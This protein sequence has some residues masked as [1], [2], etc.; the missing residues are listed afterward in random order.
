MFAETAQLGDPSKIV[1]D[2]AI[3]VEVRNP[4]QVGGTLDK[5][6]RFTVNMSTSLGHFTIKEATV[7]RRYRDFVWL[8]D[9]LCTIYPGVVIPPVPGKRIVG[10]MEDSFVEAR[11]QA[12]ME[13]L[14]RV[15]HHPRLVQSFD[16]STFLTASTDGLEALKS[17][18]ETGVSRG[19]MDLAAAGAKEAF[20]N[21]FTSIS[22]SVSPL[23]DSRAGIPADIGVDEKYK[24][25]CDK[26]SEMHELLAKAVE[27][28]NGLEVLRRRAS[29]Q[30]ARWSVCVAD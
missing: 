11:R 9:R 1:A 15:V 17:I 6:T 26:H 22:S 12:L 3:R 27:R 25:L 4:V 14:S 20:S 10:N 21:F 30:Q 18:I 23:F 28:A 7:Q 5:H 16:V 2:N 24:A 29:M 19:Q 8:H 13:Y